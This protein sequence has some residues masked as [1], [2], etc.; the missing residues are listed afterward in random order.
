MVDPDF[1]AANPALQGRDR[2]V[3]DSSVAANIGH[4]DG[5]CLQPEDFRGWPVNRTALAVGSRKMVSQGTEARPFMAERSHVCSEFIKT[6]QA[7]GYIHQ[8][9]NLQS[10][11]EKLANGLHSVGYIGFDCTADSLHVGSLLQIMMLRHFQKSGHK[12]V[13][14]LG[15]GTTKVG[16][17]SGKTETRKMLSDIEIMKNMEGIKRVFEKFLKFGNGPTD[18]I[19]VNNADWLDSLNY[20]DFLRDY[21]S[22]FTINKMLSF[23]SVKSRLEREQP[24]SFLEFNYMILQAYDFVELAKKYSCCLQMG[25]SDQWGNIVNGIELG[26]RTSGLELFGLTSPLLVTSS[27]A[28]M[29]KT[30]SGAIWLNPEKTSV[31]DYWQFW[32]N[33]D[34]ASVGEYLRLFTDLP[35]DESVRL[36]TLKGS[37]LNEAKIILAD[38][39]TRL[40][41]GENVS[42][43]E[44]PTVTFSISDF[45][46]GI[47]AISLF[48]KAG[49]A[50]SNSDARRLIQGGGAYLND[51]KITD[52][53]HT[54]FLEHFKNG[55][56]CLKAGKKRQINIK[57]Q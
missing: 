6:M 44:T 52:Q 17:P 8:C 37:E 56:V 14:L 20:I 3:Y 16:D 39:I 31:F 10:L 32:R 29:G 19:I 49:L 13:I 4:R 41:H 53:N 36:E 34:D 23:D 48:Q 42:G 40:T 54:V 57:C 22:H 24:L 25:G 5:M 2:R 46:N 33:T 43:N 26:R 30:A 9:T 45:E 47:K 18:A 38:S 11:D 28:K 7:R 51:F 1:S 27:G 21:G 15:G 12:P 35:L 55:T 50:S